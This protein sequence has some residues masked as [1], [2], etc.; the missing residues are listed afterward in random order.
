MIKSGV[1]NNDLVE[2][3]DITPT[4]LEMTDLEIPKSI[5]GRSLWSKINGSKDA[6][7]REDIYCEYYNS[8]FWKKPGVYA[9]M[10]RSR[11]Y[12]IVS[13]HS[14]NSGELYDLAND[15]NETVN[16]WYNK[17]YSDIKC[18]M[19]AKLTDR[20]AW[21]IDPLPYRSAPF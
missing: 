18:D 12:K 5:Q 13:Y 6:E 15:P 1:I 16:L 9:T 8:I 17:T 11:E 4:L 3:S 14:E 10:V 2:L 7:H 21:T 20:M 19:L